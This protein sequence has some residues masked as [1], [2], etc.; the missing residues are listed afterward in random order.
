MGSFYYWQTFLRVTGTDLAEFRLI[1]NCAYRFCN[2]FATTCAHDTF[3]GASTHKNHE[4]WP[5]FIIAKHFW[6]PQELIL[7]NFA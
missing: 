3:R 1:A 6:G 5:G 7:R 2:H 4:C